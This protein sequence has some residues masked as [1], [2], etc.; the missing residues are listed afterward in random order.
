MKWD[1]QAEEAVSRAP[2]FV[3][4]RIRKKVEEEV[5]KLGSN[6]VTLAHV[7]SCQRNFMKNME[8][9]VAGHRVEACFGR[10]GC[11]NRAM[12]SDDLC[13]EMEKMLTK[14]N[15]K[16]FLKEKVQ[17]P[18]K[19][20]HEFRISVS[21][22]PNSCSRP[23]ITD[24][25]LI[26]ARKPGVLGHEECNQCGACL[27]ICREE[28][29]TM[30]ENTN[31]PVIDMEKCLYCGQCINACPT[32]TIKEIER[33]FRIQLGGRLGRH[34]QLACELDGLYPPENVIK[35]LGECIQHYKSQCTKGERFGDV[36]NKTGYD[37]LY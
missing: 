31:K 11:S 20:H 25:G 28:A 27:E 26:G 15:L 7:R 23:Q 32:G 5:R 13:N 12:E 9:E 22:C 2:F 17:G 34:P 21:E 16:A 36:L 1:R 37:F 24:F 8:D 33:G 35:V 19:L 6:R 29:V 14:E 18:L 10:N 4:G 3:R 30:P